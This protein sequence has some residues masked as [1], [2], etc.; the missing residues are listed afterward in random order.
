MM[1]HPKTRWSIGYS[2]TFAGIKTAN[3]GSGTL[4]QGK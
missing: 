4:K 3:D 1:M 2:H